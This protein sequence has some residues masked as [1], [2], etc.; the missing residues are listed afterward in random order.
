M[1][2]HTLG[3]SPGWFLDRVAVFDLQ[4]F[5]DSGNSYFIANRWL[6]FDFHPY[7]CNIELEQASKEE[8][9]LTTT[10]WRFNFIYLLANSNAWTAMFTK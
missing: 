7:Q 6:A 1:S 3:S 9:L 2:Q 4:A 8:L 10:L 5:D